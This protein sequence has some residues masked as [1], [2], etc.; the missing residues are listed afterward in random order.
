G[1]SNGSL[2]LAIVSHDEPAIQEIAR[3]PLHVEPLGS[4]RLVLVCAVDSPWN[5][6]VRALPKDG[7]PA[8]ALTRFPL[9]L[10]EP[11]AGIRKGFDEAL[12]RRGVLGH[13]NVAL[14]TGGWMAILAY[15]REGFGVG[16]V[17]EVTLPEEKGLIVRALDPAVFPPI[18]SKLICRRPAGSGEG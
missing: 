12:H 5:R 6:G 8:E 9:I 11:D 14:E 16:I 4:H 10:P 7:A 1:V 13:L 3:R 15:V 18:E 2:D 17:S